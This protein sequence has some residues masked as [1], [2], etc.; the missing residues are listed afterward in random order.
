MSATVRE[1]SGEGSAKP[2]RRR[3][4][5]VMFADMVEYS[6][7]L[8]E[9]EI[10]NSVQATKSIKLFRSLI[11]AYGG[12]IAN[13]AG[14]GILALFESAEQGLRFASQV[15]NEF[16][17]RAV[18]SDGRPIQFRIGLSLGEI[19]IGDKVVQGHCVNIAARLQ[20]IAEPGGI[21]VTAAVHDAVHGYPEASLRSLGPRTLKNIS[22]AVEVF[23]MTG[24]P[25]AA[26]AP[27]R[28]PRVDKLPRFRQPS[29]AVLALAN[30]SGDP[31]NDHL[32]E[33][34]AE[35]VISDLSRFRNLAVIAP[36]SAFLFSLKSNS[37][38]EIGRRL[39]VDYLLAGSLRRS[40]R[41]LRI[42]TELIDVNS[43]EVLW[44]DRFE[45][46]IEGIFDLQNEIT[47][48]I[49]ARL[50]V[51][52]DFAEGRREAHFQPD[53]QA[54][55]LVLRSHQLM[56][57]FT[58]EANVH[59]RR[60]LEESIEL[61]P[62]YARAFST[63][64]R[65]HNLDWRYSWSKAPHESLETAVQLAR[66]SIQ[67]D[68]LD[69]RGF[70]ELG[71]AHLYQKRQDE[72]LAD[73]GRATALNPND[74]DIVTEYGDCLVYA[75]NPERGLEFIE[76]A[77]RL[78]PYYPDW[79]LWCMADAYWTMGRPRDVIGAVH[80]MQNPSEARR[81]LAVSY[82]ELDMLDDARL[83]A[84]EIL[85]RDPG[86]RVGVW[87]QRPPHRD[88]ATIDRFAEGLRKAG[89]PE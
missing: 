42:A 72:A 78:N 18:W 14:D 59:A 65:T 75:G 33:G 13:V 19:T 44:S 71:F 52:I 81:L 9:D 15:Q 84:R 56:L 49:A 53:M 43:E 4:A 34:I 51:Q 64:S 76:K 1:K 87:R 88:M 7:Y 60:L 73:Y 26:K 67:R 79:Y 57:R 47:T 38:R 25:E 37:P 22:G 5:A 3:L 21:Y 77:M 45:I 48:A 32:C 28:T 61:A 40:D 39:G 17:D 30:Q 83:Q 58:K 36:Y 55:G 41:R 86:F 63:L 68:Q 62:L 85:S 66:E 69:A 82:A 27:A 35:D 12:R 70:A 11:G 23:A 74:A 80:R 24:S 29:I 16:R 46:G 8:E 50:S 89:L 54:H 31:A 6:R 2:P 20:S 10:R